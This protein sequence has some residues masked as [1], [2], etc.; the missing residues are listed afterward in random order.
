MLTMA[1]V[2]TA[3]PCNTGVYPPLPPLAGIVE[4]H[5]DWY[6]A[7]VPVAPH[8]LVETIR[9]EAGPYAKVTDGKGRF[10]YLHSKTIEQAG[11]R[12]ATVLHGGPNGHPNVE[13]SGSVYAPRLA[14]L[15]RANGEHRVT[16]C[17]VAVDLFGEG[18]FERLRD[19]AGHIADEHGLSCRDVT[20]R[21][22]TKG[23]TR[24]IGSR[25]SPVFARI[26]EKGK[27][28]GQTAAKVELDQLRHWVRIE[29]E[30]KPQKAMKEK[31][32]RLEPEQFWGVSPWTL[33][34]AKGALAMDA[35]PIPFTPR[36]NTNDERAFAHCMEQYGETFRRLCQAK[37][38]GDQDAFLEAI[39]RRVF[40]QGAKLAS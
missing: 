2:A 23:D 20:D 6:R 39:R 30:I 36:R 1:D 19:M 32:A 35:Q 14:A 25:K 31:A 13:A 7:T 4:S 26:Y 5:F 38:Q 3:P 33:D 34:L 11:D 22:R 40:E 16:R 12:V 15:L 17:D 28:G 29:L 8:I 10:N 9:R 27:A 18:L 24:Y 37:Y 21:D